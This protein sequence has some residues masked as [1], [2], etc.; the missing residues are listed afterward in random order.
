MTGKKSHKPSK[1]LTLKL[2]QFDSAAQAASSTGIP[3]SCWRLAK[4]R[5]CPAFRHSR[6]DF[7]EFLRWWFAQ[8][9]FDA[10][11]NWTQELAKEKTLRERIRRAEDE[12]RMIDRSVVEHDIAAGEAALFSELDRVFTS[13]FPA[14]AKGMDEVGIRDLAVVEIERIKARLKER[15]SE[16]G[17]A[18]VVES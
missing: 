8:S 11:Q 2:P 3:L 12:R 13:T 4:K 5:G 17:A 7:G 14:R 16:I 1:P 15:W 6:I 10:G 18:E 9:E